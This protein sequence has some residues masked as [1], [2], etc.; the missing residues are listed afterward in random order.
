MALKIRFIEGLAY[1]G[2]GNS[3]WWGVAK[4]GANQDKFYVAADLFCEDGKVRT[5]SYR[6]DGFFLNEREAAL[7]ATEL[8]KM[9][10]QPFANGH[11]IDPKYK[12]GQKFKIDGRF[13][14]A[15]DK[16]GHQ[17]RSTK[18]ISRHA[19]VVWGTRN[20]GESTKTKKGFAPVEGVVD[21]LEESKSRVMDQE[22]S[23]KRQ[24]SDDD[25]FLVDRLMKDASG[26][27][28]I[29][30]AVKAFATNLLNG[31]QNA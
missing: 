5:R 20:R 14:K 17:I 18:A 11:V 4:N 9:G 27:S 1:S 3:P 16:N 25:W 26:E 28:E 22:K 15:I 21:K 19:N 10:G 31:S 2:R 13:I 24:I 8:Y 12:T 29:N 6:P 7:I 30:P 23:I